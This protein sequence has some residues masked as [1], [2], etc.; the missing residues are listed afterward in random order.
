VHCYTGA[1]AETTLGD[2]L[3]IPAVSVAQPYLLQ[4]SSPSSAFFQTSTSPPHLVFKMAGLREV[5]VAAISSIIAPVS[6]TFGL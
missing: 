6:L 5:V 4:I 1:S 2:S 3:E